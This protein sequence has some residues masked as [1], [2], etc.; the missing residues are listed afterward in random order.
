MNAKLQNEE[1][2][3]Q[4]VDELNW[5]PVRRDTR[6]SASQ[7]DEFKDALLDGEALR[8]GLMVTSCL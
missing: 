8:Y 4:L 7:S 5:G 6:D 2:P 1:G 3:T